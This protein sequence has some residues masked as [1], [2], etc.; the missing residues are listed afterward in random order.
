MMSF[1]LK[2]LLIFNPLPPRAL[3]DVI[4]PVASSHINPL[5]PRALYDVIYPVASSY[6]NPSPPRALMS[7]IT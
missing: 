2:P 6:I 5:P 1:I 3:Y 4:Y 7:F